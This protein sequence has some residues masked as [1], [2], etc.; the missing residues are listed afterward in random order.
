LCI[1]SGNVPAALTAE[2]AVE[3]VE[4]F[5]LETNSKSSGHI[6]GLVVRALRE[7]GR[8]DDPTVA[9]IVWFQK[10]IVK[11]KSPDGVIG[12]SERPCRL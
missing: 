2:P 1:V 11:M 10:N 6:V 12:V 7:T 4:K 3:N 5:G 8:I 9:A